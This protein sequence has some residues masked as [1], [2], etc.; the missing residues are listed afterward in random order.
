ML[1]AAGHQNPASM[2]LRESSIPDDF[3]LT[4]VDQY[5][6]FDGGA[7]M[8]HAERRIFPGVINESE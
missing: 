8:L 3:A 5:G 6:R 4:V 7:E 1:Q 2:S